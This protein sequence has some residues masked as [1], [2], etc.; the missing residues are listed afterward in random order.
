MERFRVCPPDTLQLLQE[1]ATVSADPVSSKLNV[2]SYRQ[3]TRDTGSV[4]VSK[5]PDGTIILDDGVNR[6]VQRPFNHPER[7]AARK[8]QFW[9]QVQTFCSD[10][11]RMIFR[12]RAT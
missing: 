7:R 3:G 1:E 10:L 2:I 11:S 5:Y 6:V 9:K 12:R 4:T 8:A